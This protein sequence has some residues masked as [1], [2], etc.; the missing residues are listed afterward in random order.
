MH[1]YLILKTVHIL[2]ATIWLGSGLTIA[3]D[4]R[5]TIAQ[6]RPHTDL[7]IPRVNR[8]GKT[9]GIFGMLTVLSGINMVFTMGGFG[10]VGHNIHAGLGLSL[11][12]FA[13][14]LGLSMPTWRRIRAILGTEAGDLG[15]ARKLA[16]RLGMF[17]GI[18]HLLWLVVLV[19]MVMKF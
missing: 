18:E 2:C 10:N 14:S 8:Q 17:T 7:L 5:R 11:L 9:A 3:G 16:G 6:G 13:V 4:V 15:E 12:I 1:L 19:L